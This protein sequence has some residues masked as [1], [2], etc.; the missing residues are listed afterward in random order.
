MFTL[1]AHETPEHRLYIGVTQQRPIRRWNGGEGYKHSPR[2][3]S[4]VK[5]YGWRNIRHYI[6][7]T[8]ETAA[9]AYEAERETIRRGRFTELGYNI[10][11]GGLEPW[12]KGKTGI[13]TPEALER[14]SIAKIGNQ[15][16][17]KKGV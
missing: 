11:P 2:F 9:E 14:M 5:K 3:Y 12:N 4:V 13:Y 15:N 10:A 8:Y 1:Y 17:R 7:G 16:A 6:L